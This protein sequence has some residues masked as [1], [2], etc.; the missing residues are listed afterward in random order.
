MKW[1]MKVSVAGASLHVDVEVG[2]WG[3][4]VASEQVRS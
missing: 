1:K 3:G 4:D 2:G